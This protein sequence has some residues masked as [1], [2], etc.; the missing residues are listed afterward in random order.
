MTAGGGRFLISTGIAR[1]QW[2]FVVQR[3]KVPVLRIVEYYRL[4]LSE[5]LSCAEDLHAELESAQAAGRGTRQ[6]R[7]S[8]DL[9]ASGE[10]VV[11]GFVESSDLDGDRVRPITARPA[12]D[13]Y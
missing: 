2:R 12:L 4:Q 1:E 7:N 8:A 13:H 3:T 9:A 11:R 6:K 10:S 5:G